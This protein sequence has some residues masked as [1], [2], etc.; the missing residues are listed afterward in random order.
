MVR[1]VLIAVALTLRLAPG[2]AAAPWPGAGL[3]IS[4][5][6]AGAEAE[7]AWSIPSGLLAAIG[8]MESGRVDTGSGQVVAWPW[9]INANGQG[10]YFDTRADAIAAVQ[11]LQMRGVRSIDVGCFQINMAFHPRAFASLDEAFDARLNASYAARFL[12]ELHDRTGSWETA[13]A[14]YHSA[15]PGIGESY[16]NKVLADWSDGGLRILPAAQAA[17]ASRAARA[18][19]PLVWNAV[20]INGVRVWT[21]AASLSASARLQTVSAQ[22]RPRPAARLPRIITPRS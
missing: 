7:R 22:R 21:P 16:R 5:H 6:A 20:Q 19:T 10:A 3:D 17:P 12:S 11:A 2:A 15:T 1:P 18:A 13:V 9:T 4:C 8:R 14:W